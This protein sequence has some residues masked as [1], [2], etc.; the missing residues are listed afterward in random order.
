MA[1]RLSEHSGL[2]PRMIERVQYQW[3]LVTEM[4]NVDES[5]C[6]KDEFVQNSVQCALQLGE[7]VRLYPCL[8]LVSHRIGNGLTH[9]WRRELLGADGSV[10]SIYNYV[11][12]QNSMCQ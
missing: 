12:R 4:R 9:D 3:V 11:D 7:D 1:G 5:T 2:T 8:R 6:V 10:A